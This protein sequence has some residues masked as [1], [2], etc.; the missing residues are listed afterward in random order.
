MHT[1]GVSGTDG[2]PIIFEGDILGQYTGDTPGEVVFTGSNEYGNAV[3]NYA[4]VFTGV[5][6]RQWKNIVFGFC[7]QQSRRTLRL[8]QIRS[9]WRE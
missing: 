4:V 7:A 1:A 2:N 8:R 9:R 3:R 6:F 5:T